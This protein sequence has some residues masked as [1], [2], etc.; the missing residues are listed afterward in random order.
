MEFS[1]LLTKTFLQTKIPS[2]TAYVGMLFSFSR[3][4]MQKFIKIS[5]LI[6][7]FLLSICLYSP[8]S[9]S[10]NQ[11]LPTS[12]RIAL[13]KNHLSTQQLF[14]SVKPLDGGQLRLNW[15]A[16]RKVSPA[17]TEK[18]ITTLA[19]LETLG[20]NWRWSTQFLLD[21]APDNGKLKGSL[22]VLGG[23][24]PTYVIENLWR[25][26]HAMKLKGLREIQGNIVLDRSLF[27]Y[28]QSLV[29]FGSDIQRPYMKEAD[30]ALLNYQ[31]VTLDIQPDPQ[32]N[33]AKITATPILNGLKVPKTVKLTDSYANCE[34]WR[35]TLK[36]NLDNEWEPTF[37]GEFPRSCPNKK[38]SYVIRDPLTY[39]Q[40]LLTPL[41]KEV[42]IRWKG[43]VIEGPIPEKALLF[44]TA[45]SEDL[46]HISRLTNK[47]SNNVL[48][49]HIYLTFGLQQH[50]Q[51]RSATYAM[52]RLSLQK[53]LKENVRINPHS[54]F[55]DNGSGLSR[56]SYVTAQAMTDIIR[57]GW[58]S[59]RMPEWLS[60]F[61]VSATDGTMR[62]RQ[63]APSSAYIKTGLLNG[64]KS[65]AGVVQAKSGKRYAIF[66]VVQGEQAT[67]TDAPL[68]ALIQWVYLKG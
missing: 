39:W 33:V 34:G 1:V 6:T 60:T 29:S 10:A 59:P 57:Y 11:K 17:S 32:N 49:R 43:N 14:A 28:N 54:V 65:I 58:R 23:G 56:E 31:A 46:V 37:D 68:D 9:F 35:H 15:Q 7:L 25:D 41:M 47:Y 18:I 45:Y 12:V 53:W 24:D 67:S 19:A 42:G 44:Y 16:N 61:P 4:K 3:A 2:Y 13:Q 55:V 62:K 21:A 48:A 52:A 5:H 50:E 51:K 20:P 36:L 8:F 63:V 27:S 64:V 40:A 22:Y 66:G 38:L 26:L 30:A